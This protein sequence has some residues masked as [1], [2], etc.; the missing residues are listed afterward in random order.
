M[1]KHSR[2]SPAPATVM[3]EADRALLAPILA[4]FR[5]RLSDARKHTPG[6]QLT[7]DDITGVRRTTAA[8]HRVT[9]EDLARWYLAYPEATA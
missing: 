7:C 8:R 9:P 5:A 3:A 6:G 4:D 1:T 2:L